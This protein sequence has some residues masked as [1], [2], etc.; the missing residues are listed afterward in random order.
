MIGNKF[1]W[2]YFAMYMTVWVVG[3]IITFVFAGT[4]YFRQCTISCRY[5]HPFSYHTAHEP[6]KF[7]DY[8]FSS[9]K[10]RCNNQ[11]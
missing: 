7:Q 3:I 9:C 8:P 10:K 6:I 5:G 11:R 1:F 2:A 4:K